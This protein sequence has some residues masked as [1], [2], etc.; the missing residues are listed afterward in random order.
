[1]LFEKD[2]N[3]DLTLPDLQ[4]RYPYMIFKLIGMGEQYR[5]QKIVLYDLKIPSIQFD[6]QFNEDII[7]PTKVWTLTIDDEAHAFGLVKLECGDFGTYEKFLLGEPASPH[8]NLYRQAIFNFS[9]EVKLSHHL[10][11]EKGISLNDVKKIKISLDGALWLESKIIALRSYR[12][13]ESRLISIRTMLSNYGVEIN[14]YSLI[15]PKLIPEIEEMNLGLRGLYACNVGEL[16]R[17][18]K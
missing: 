6:E 5:A 11:K 10:D 14:D 9:K 2:Y 15:I 8:W 4:T 13:F 7:K 18:Q 1:M 12:D 3:Y 16:L 17:K